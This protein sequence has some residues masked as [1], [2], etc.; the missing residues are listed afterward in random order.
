M[1]KNALEHALPGISSAETV[2]H[3]KSKNS[4]QS[5]YGDEWEEQLKSYLA[6]FPFRPITD[7][8]TFMTEETHRLMQ[9]TAH[10]GNWYFG[11]TRCL[12]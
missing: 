3:R 5:R 4:Y 2:Y 6:L 9:G 1:Y 11:M 8:V 10:E 12:Y 7:L